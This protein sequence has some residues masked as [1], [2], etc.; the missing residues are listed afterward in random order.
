MRIS[1]RLTVLLAIFAASAGLVLF[2]DSDRHAIGQEVVEATKPKS[3]VTADHLASG[4][5]TAAANQPMI[6]ALLPRGAASAE[7]S[8]PFA[9]HDW[10]PPPPPPPPPLPPPPPQAPQMPF[11]YLGKE[12]VDGRLEVFIS[13]QDRTFIVREED[14]IEGTYRVDK[15]SPPTMVFTYLP[16]K[17]QQTLSI[18][19]AQ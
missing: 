8:D 15:I 10:T 5:K 16:L 2:G 13:R 7:Q 19:N 1:R 12:L 14:V 3:R 18:G 17:Q 4:T 11:A 6:L 9:T